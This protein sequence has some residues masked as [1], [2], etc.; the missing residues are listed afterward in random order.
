M[1]TILTGMKRIREYVGEG[2]AK[3]MLDS[4]IEEADLQ[5]TEIKRK[6]IQ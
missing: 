6:V 5:V 3:E 4:L 2:L 1:E